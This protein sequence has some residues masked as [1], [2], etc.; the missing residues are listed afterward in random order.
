MTANRDKKHYVAVV[1][2]ED[3]RFVREGW[4]AAVETS[5]DLILLGAYPSCEEAF[6]SGEIGQADVVML[7][8][9]RPGGSATSSR[10]LS[11]EWG[12][13]VHGSR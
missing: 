9:E 6:A 2:I 8:I 1:I 3:N 7:D 10:V 13:H 4:R 11:E 5:S 12:R